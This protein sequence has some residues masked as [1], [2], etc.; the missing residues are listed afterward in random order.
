[1][2]AFFAFQQAAQ[3]GVYLHPNIHNGLALGCKDKLVLE[4]ASVHDLQGKRKTLRRLVVRN[5]YS[6]EGQHK[7][8]MYRLAISLHGSA[9]VSPVKIRWSCID[10]AVAFQCQ[11]FSFAIGKLQQ[12]LHEI[13]SQASR[14]RVC[15]STG[16]RSRES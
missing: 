7:S 3:D 10:F 2:T 12:H 14:L 5:D 8:S 4:L 13:P 9:L 16:E 11:M 6:D 15:C 1:M